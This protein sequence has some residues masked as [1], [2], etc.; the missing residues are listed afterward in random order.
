MTKVSFN[1]FNQ[2]TKTHNNYCNAFNTI[3]G[4]LIFIIGILPAL[5]QSACT[6]N[7]AELSLLTY[8]DATAHAS[9][10]DFDMALYICGDLFIKIE[11]E[12]RHYWFAVESIPR[13]QVCTYMHCARQFIYFALSIDSRRAKTFF[14]VQN[15]KHV[16]KYIQQ[17][18][19]SQFSINKRMRVECRFQVGSMSKST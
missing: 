18:N 14:C 7:L 6:E 16:P 1:R 3:L 17:L 8:A 15:G 5:I 2:S 9:A 10:F 11:L 19:G 13:P 4:G 12:R